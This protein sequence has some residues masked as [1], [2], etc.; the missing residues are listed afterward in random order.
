MAIYKVE[1]AGDVVYID[2]PTE[3]AARHY[4]ERIMGKIPS[5][6]IKF[7]VADGIPEGEEFL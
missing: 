1:A 6:L 2:E 4:L 5:Q 7:S 3:K